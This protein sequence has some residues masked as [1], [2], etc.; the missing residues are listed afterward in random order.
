MVPGM[1]GQVLTVQ[2]GAKVPGPLKIDIFRFD[3][4]DVIYLNEKG[5]VINTKIPNMLVTKCTCG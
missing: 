4:L 5:E 1:A 2:D 3:S